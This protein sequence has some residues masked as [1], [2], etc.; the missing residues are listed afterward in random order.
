MSALPSCV[1]WTGSSSRSREDTKLELACEKEAGPG[2]AGVYGGGASPLVA[3]LESPVLGPWATSTT[4]EIVVVTLCL[5]G[6]GPVD[7][8]SP[9]FA[10]APGRSFLRLRRRRRK[11]VNMSRKTA[12]S[13]PLT[14][15]STN[16]AD[17]GGF[18][19]G[20]E[21]G[22]GAGIVV[23]GVRDVDTEVEWMEDASGGLL[24][25]ERL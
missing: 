9:R 13:P 3:A 16:F 21:L 22:R 14:P 12:K 11:T 25:V 7:S 8:L 24:E 23:L 15:P 19:A 10:T 2:G 17:V 18:W 20:E 4:P 5:S 6:T 1:Y